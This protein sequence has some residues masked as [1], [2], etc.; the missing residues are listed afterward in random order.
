MS[1]K[2]K[3]T[4]QNPGGDLPADQGA[5]VAALRK[6]AAGYRSKLRE[7]EGERDKLS[8]RLGVLQRGEAERIA[9]TAADDFASPLRAGDD[10]WKADV[11]LD[12]LL[13]DDGN[14]DATVVRG[15][16]AELAES[17]PHWVTQNPGDSDA[18][19]GAGAAVRK[20]SFGEAMKAA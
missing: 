11:E 5:D 4:N 6:E 15:K 8:E 12:H 14:L 18:G 16:V 17:R 1:E 9:S 2:D 19:K 20:A 7:V 3:D 13:D 10:L